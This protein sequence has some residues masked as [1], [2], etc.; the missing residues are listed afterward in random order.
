MGDFF[1][2]LGKRISE[3]A[4]A[5]TKKTEEVVETQK[6]RNQIR[7]MERSNQ[8]DYE[9]LGKMIYNRFKKGEEINLKYIELCEEIE[10]REEAIEVYLKEIA[11]LKGK[12][13]CQQCKGEL[14]AGM[15]YC[16]KCGAKVGEEIFEEEIVPEEAA[17]EIVEEAAEEILEEDAEAA[18]E[19]SC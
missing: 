2:D 5:V 6:I 17:E 8:R 10:Q 7:V 15:A 4:E 13:I 19:E 14:D 9:A 11:E 1:E 16:P 12:D 3:T 18:E